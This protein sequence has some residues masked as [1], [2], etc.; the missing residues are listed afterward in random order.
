MIPIVIFPALSVRRKKL[1][2]IEYLSIK[3]FEGK[4]RQNNG[5]RTTTGTLATLTAAAGKDMYLAKAKVTVYDQDA[6]N[7][8]SADIELSFNG[9]VQETVNL[10]GSTETQGTFEYEFIITGLKVAAG[11][12]IKLEV[13]T[14]QATPFTIR[15][16][17]ECW[18]EPTGET[19]QIPSI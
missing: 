11:Q 16:V 2:D 5:T 10:G 15:G 4:T 8:E 3:E 6:G 14:I 19:P 17:I 18:E 9:V 12:I 7:T 13:V 1:S